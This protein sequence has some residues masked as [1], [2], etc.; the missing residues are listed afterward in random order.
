M[1]RKCRIIQ[2][3]NEIRASWDDYD[4]TL[5]AECETEVEAKI[6]LVK[7]RDVLQSPTPSAAEMEQVTAARLKLKRTLNGIGDR[8]E[9]QVREIRECV[10]ESLPAKATHLQKVL[11]DIIQEIPDLQKAAFRVQH[12]ENW[13]AWELARQRKESSD[14]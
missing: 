14:A 3:E 11:L 2:I 7:L 9:Q 1:K 13:T 10:D 5:L 12:C 4:S 8:L 6:L